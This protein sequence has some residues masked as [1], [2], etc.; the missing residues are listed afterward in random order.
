MKILFLCTGNS[1]RSILYVEEPE[2]AQ[3]AAFREATR[4]LARRIELFTNLPLEK[5]DRQAE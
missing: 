5:L 4:V 2:E 1:A 3:H